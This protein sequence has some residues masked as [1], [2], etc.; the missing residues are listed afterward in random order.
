M[1]DRAPPLR[2]PVTGNAVI[3]SAFGDIDDYMRG[4]LRWVE[5][6][7]FDAIYTEPLFVKL[8]N[9]PLGLVLV[10]VRPTTQLTSAL[11]AGGVVPFE[12]DGVGSRAKI[13]KV[14]GL[15]VGTDYRFSF[16]AVG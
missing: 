16:I 1:T 2:R 11:I 3:D 12:W 4:T 14:S 8:D 7:Q 6:P 10:R 15:T 5:V 13:L 9:E